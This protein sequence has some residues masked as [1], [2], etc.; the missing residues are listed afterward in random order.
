M[1]RLTTLIKI[2]KEVALGVLLSAAALIS[3]LSLV[4]LVPL[5]NVIFS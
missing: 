1:T 4:F 5:C 2:S 3:T